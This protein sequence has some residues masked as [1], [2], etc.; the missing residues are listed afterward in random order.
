MKRCVWLST[1]LFAA[2]LS[3]V[4]LQAD[5]CTPAGNAR[6]SALELWVPDVQGEN[7]IEGFRPDALW[8][9]AYLP[10]SEATAVLHVT[11]QDPTATI[12]VR[13]DGALKPLVGDQ[14][15]ALDVPMDESE[16]RIKVSVDTG[17]TSP[18]FWNYVVTVHRGGS[19]GLQI[20]FDVQ[21]TSDGGVDGG[22]QTTGDG[23]AEG[24][25][26]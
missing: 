22:V 26:P 14:Y 15:A 4:V 20:D 21:I 12:E 8:Y 9:D 13:H 17:G 23:G 7:V 6:L 3:P 1:F 24:G 16:L 10:E 5:T 25:V 11:A 18:Y 2:V 19:G